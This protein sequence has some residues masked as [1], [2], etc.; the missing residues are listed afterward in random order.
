MRS[1]EGV[2][3]ASAVLLV[4]AIGGGLR[5]WWRAL[6]SLP[7]DI[8]PVLSTLERVT[9]L[10]YMRPCIHAKDCV[11]PLSCGLYGPLQVNRCLA[12]NCG[13]DEDCEP[14]L[15]CRLIVANPED[16]R[17]CVVAGTAKEGEL[18]QE[19]PEDQTKSCLPGLRCS[20][21]YCGR[22]CRL[23]VPADCPEGTACKDDTN[24]PACVPACKEGG[25]P[26][27]QQC[28]GYDGLTAC[29]RLAGENCD[30]VPCPQGQECVR[31]RFGLGSYAMWCIPLCPPDSDAGCQA[32]T[33][34]RRGSCVAPCPGDGGINPCKPHWSCSP[35]LDDG[36]R[37][38]GPD[39]P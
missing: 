10:T 30:D 2:A 38:C 17:I 27:G 6:P 11:P 16:V 24:G 7:P 22:P 12:S 37:V 32:G 18:C 14:G 34:C 26:A 15:F 3:V 35:V 13:G 4:I 25:C 9:H 28:I 21:E 33:V 31:H 23:D 20:H 39:P 29:G 36:A 19:S 5:W 1:R 8:R